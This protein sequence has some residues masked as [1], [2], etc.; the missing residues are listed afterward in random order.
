MGL[1]VGIDLDGVLAAMDLQLEREVES[2][3]GRP[4]PVSAL[5]PRQ[6]RQ[7]WRQVGMR[8]DFWEQL[9]ELEIGAVQRLAGIAAHRRWQVIFLTKRTETLG[10]TAQVQSQH[11]LESHG[12]V[13]PSVFVV[14]GSRGRI[15]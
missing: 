9:R 15:A 12:F 1:R 2:L 3:F 4:S 7:V 6:Q 10:A 14:H 8:H 5:T 13:L 11:W